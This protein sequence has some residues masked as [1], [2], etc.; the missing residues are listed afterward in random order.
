MDEFCAITGVDA[1]TSAMYMEMSGNDLDTAIQLFFSMNDGGGGG[2]D[3]GG[4]S[5][6]QSGS[7]WPHDWISVLFSSSDNLSIPSSWLDQGLLTATPGGSQPSEWS[8]FSILQHKNGPCGVLAAYQG[9]LLAHTLKN[10]ALSPSYKPT[11]LDACHSVYNILQTVAC[12]QP[13]I[14]VCSWVDPV[15]GIGQT[16]NVVDGNMEVLQDIIIQFLNP[17]GV[18]LLLY[19]AVHTF[20]IETL[21]QQHSQLLPLL[22]GPNYLCSSALM[23]ILLSGEAREALGAYDDFGA[24]ISWN[25]PSATVGLLSGTEI[26]LKMKIHDGFKFPL[27]EVYV[28]HGRDHFTTLLLLPALPPTPD[29]PPSSTPWKVTMPGPL[30]YSE[31]STPSSGESIVF[32]AIHFNGLPPAGP[33]VTQVTAMQA[34]SICL[35][36][37]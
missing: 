24:A 28:L 9:Y 7:S 23:N 10:Q 20:G 26:E 13:T 22:F 11:S 17:G 29:A 33:S 12:G 30:P 35:H 14:K 6:T 32:R 37:I 16:V 5:A 27:Q 25:K 1:A 4:T 3:I 34:L 8:E 15:S 18:L 21:R 2:G 19:S 31:E 36:D